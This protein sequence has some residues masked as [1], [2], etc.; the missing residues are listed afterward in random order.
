MK[1]ILKRAGLSLAGLLL[2]AGLAAITFKGYREETTLE[3]ASPNI[4]SQQAQ[5]REQ[6]LARLKFDTADQGDCVVHDAWL[7]KSSAWTTRAWFGFHLKTEEL[8]MTLMYVVQEIPASPLSASNLHFNEEN[9]VAILVGSSSQRFFDGEHA[10]WMFASN[11]VFPP[12]DV[13][14]FSC[15]E[16]EFSAQVE[17]LPAPAN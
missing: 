3:S 17:Y 6:L 5:Q 9:P 12:P 13:L 4:S 14:K 7:E 1:R 11:T 15:G 16:K 10:Y 8:P 2:L